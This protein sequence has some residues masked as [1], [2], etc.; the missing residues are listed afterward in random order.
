MQVER[1]FDTKSNTNYFLV[2]IKNKDHNGKLL[3]LKHA[4]TTKKAGESVLEFS[5]RMGNPMIAINGSQTST[6]NGK[7]E[8]ID[9]QIVNGE[10]I[11][12][13]RK[14]YYAYTLGI[15][16][17]NELSAFKKEIS[18][19]EI[20]S[21]GVTNA[22]SGFV[23]LIENHKAVPASV[24]EGTKAI[25]KKHPRQVIAQFDNLDLVVLS[26]GGRGYAG[27]R[28][29]SDRTGKTPRKPGVR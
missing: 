20:L 18:A 27:C 16:D 26:C 17:N 19:T 5:T 12:D 10:I 28:C 25:Q 15:K 4:H 8:A 14:S 3:K 6:T 23:P 29:S 22:L 1:H 7:I 9:K 21:R 2:T 24:L 11:Q 13:E